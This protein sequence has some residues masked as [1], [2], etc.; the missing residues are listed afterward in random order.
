[1]TGSGVAGP[2]RGQ[3]QAV[4]RRVTA[5]AHLVIP[6]VI[7]GQIARP[8]LVERLQTGK[9]L[10]LVVAPAGFGKTTLLAQWA[11]R[12]PVSSV[13]WL[14]CDQSH[15]D[16]TRFWAALLASVGSTWPGVG[17]HAVVLLERHGESAEVAI[18]LANSLGEVPQEIALAVDDLH[19]AR[20]TPWVL[21][22]FLQ[23]LPD[24]VRVVVGSRVDPPVSL[25][26]Q[27]AAGQVVEIR[28]DDLRFS[29]EES[30][31]FL[32]MAG[33]EIGPQE[34]RGLYE[35][36]EGWPAGL[37]MALLSIRQEADPSRFLQTFSGTERGLSD[38]LV[39]EVLDSLSPD[40]VEF[41]LETSVLDSFDVSL[42]EATI[43]HDQAQ[44]SLQQL[45]E[46]HLFLVP[47]DSFGERF[48]YHNLFGDFLRARLKAQGIARWRMAHVRAADALLAR[49]DVV[50]AMRQVTQLTDVKQAG[51]TL[52][53]ALAKSLD[54][55]DRE[56]SA[57]VARA[58]LQD[59]GRRS[60]LDDPIQV[61]DFVMALLLASSSAEA[62]WWLRRVEEEHPV[63]SAELEARVSDLW[64]TYYLS[65][66][67]ADLA[68]SRAG[69]TVLAVGRWGRREGLLSNGPV[70]LAL[71]HLQAGDLA[72]ANKALADAGSSPPG[73][74]IT[75]QVRLPALA[76]YVAACEGELSRAEAAALRSVRAADQLDLGR[77]EVGRIVGS[78]ALAMVWRERNAGDQ[79][80]PL[81]H[82]A[83]RGA[84]DV[85]RPWLLGLVA[86]EQAARCAVMGDVAAAFEWIASVE[87]W[88]PQR[89]ERVQLY[90]DLQAARL[91]VQ[92]GDGRAPRLLAGLAPSPAASLL[93]AHHA[94]VHGERRLA[95]ELLDEIDDLS[96]TRRERVERAVTLALI[97]V[98]HDAE[99]AARFLAQA[100]TLAG[101]ER[102]VRCV[103]DV[104]P[105][106]GEL[107]RAHRAGPGQEDYLKSLAAAA[108]DASVAWT[109][110]PL[111]SHLDPLSARELKVLRY[112]SS[113]LTY[114]EIASLLYVSVNTLKSHVRAIYRKLEVDSRPEAVRAGRALGLM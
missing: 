45:L 17:D 82:Q 70:L 94:L 76:A 15:R 90:L 79:A 56:G 41:M 50:G 28:E 34:L 81:L 66:G 48:R 112:L 61:L 110:T 3:G 111:A 33:V 74:I 104:G 35:L 91:A 95:A 97:L 71:A 68:I 36:V 100:L 53:A 86:L 7:P 64:A 72:G 52:R 29:L 96:L 58:W 23:A 31:R 4:A 98:D 63:C 51:A 19:M 13:A 75:D 11:T 1:M 57:A 9:R 65:Q 107:L 103:V 18:S 40:L 46:A 54:I 6:Q 25:A 24:N 92:S 77:T 78:L 20:L 27:K 99:G 59:Y 69:A 109:A 101:P 88:L 43:G 67:Q 108:D 102:L 80:G 83:K 32:T 87:A 12:H 93:R 89:S 84:D 114:K 44:R 105:G 60:L 22:T 21:L 47:L 38:F 16:P 42:A 30:A 55:P 73:S 62:V 37:K 85:G 10:T 5:E 8:H 49:G 14:S 39:A 113:R 106:V 26:R 2:G